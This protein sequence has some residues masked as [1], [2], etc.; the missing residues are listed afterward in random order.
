MTVIVKIN[1]LEAL[2]SRLQGAENMAQQLGDALDTAMGQVTVPALAVY[3]PPTG[4]GYVRT[5]KLK[6]G[7]TATDRKFQVSGKIVSVKAVNPVGYGHWV[8]GERQAKVHQGRWQTVQQVSDTNKDK[9]ISVVVKRLQE[10]VD[11]LAN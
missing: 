1:G 5:Y 10:I 2:V 3:P 4:G 9:A 7:W 8:Q 11:G 6:R